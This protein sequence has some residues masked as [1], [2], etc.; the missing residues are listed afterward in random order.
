MRGARELDEW[1]V[2][3]RSS[4]NEHTAYGH[5]KSKM[6]ESQLKNDEYC[7]VNSYVH[8]SYLVAYIRSCS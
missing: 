2:M 1:S 5:E 7:A 6:I 4:Q 8:A 3:K